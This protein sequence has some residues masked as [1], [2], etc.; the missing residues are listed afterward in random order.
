MTPAVLAEG[1]SFGSGKDARMLSLDD[2]RW[3]ELQSD[4]SGPHKFLPAL[5]RLAA[6]PASA[7]GVVREFEE[8]DYVCHQRCP[9]QTALAVVPH[10]I[11]AAGRLPPPARVNLLGAAGFYAL[12]IGVPA[13]AVGGMALP[14]WLADDYHQA[15]RDALPLTGEALAAA[16]S[17]EDPEADQLRLMMA[18]AAFHGRRTGW[19]LARVALGVESCRS[20][21]AEFNIL[22]EWGVPL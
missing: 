14:G 6:N 22:D 13:E 16:P 20:C 17:G 1:L 3:Y 8:H 12:L 15:V 18:L 2:P 21:G 4:Y 10:F 11:H 7:P 9:C 19:V 5:R